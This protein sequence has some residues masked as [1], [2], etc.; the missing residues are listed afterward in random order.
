[1][2]EIV[3]KEL[4]IQGAE[5]ARFSAWSSKL[6]AIKNLLKKNSKVHDYDLII[7]DNSKSKACCPNQLPV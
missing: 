5:D 4:L 1:M 3:N 6:L 7:T 2:T